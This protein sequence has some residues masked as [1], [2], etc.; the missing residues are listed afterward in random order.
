MKIKIVKDF[1]A[2]KSGAEIAIE[3]NKINYFVGLNGSGK[4]VTF[5]A[6]YKHI[7]DIFQKNKIVKKKNWMVNPPQHLQEHF[8]FEGFE[9]IKDIVFITA[10]TRQSQWVDL[11]LCFD[12]ALG[13]GSLH[14]SEGMTNQAEIVKLMDKK[15]EVDTL[16]MFDEIDGPLDYRA[17]SIYF[18][19]VLPRL[20]GT[21]IVCSH[22]ALFFTGKDV[23][24][25]TTASRKNIVDYVKENTV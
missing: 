24:D 13:V 3:P 8:D 5:G 10:K 7:Q 21:V 9:S 2:L 11:D 16:F 12:T 20:K 1:K 18:D 6:L 22:D 15:D 4:T 23:Y 17:K 19:R 25:F 14:A